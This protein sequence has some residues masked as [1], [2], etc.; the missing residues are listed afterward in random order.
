L[1]T[2]FPYTTQ[3]YQWIHKISTCFLCALFVY[4]K[5]N[6][7]HIFELSLKLYCNQKKGV[8]RRIS[9]VGV[10]HS[11]NITFENLNTIN[12]NKLH[13]QGYKPSATRNSIGAIELSN[14]SSMFNVSIANWYTHG[15]CSLTCHNGSKQFGPCT[16]SY[17]Q[18]SKIY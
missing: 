9:Y 14:Q 3:K 5:P 12:S 15:D 17:I 6:S 4:S 10:I 7:W 8:E 13:Y 11:R 16:E 2:C 18:K 1:T